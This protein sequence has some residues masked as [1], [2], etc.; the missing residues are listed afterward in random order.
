M[1]ARLLYGGAGEI[2][3]VAAGNY[4]AGE[5][6]SPTITGAGVAGVVSGSAPVKTGDRFTVLTRGVFELASASATTISKGAVAHW[7][8]TSNLAVASGGDFRVGPAL[9]A[10]TSGQLKVLVN[11][12]EFG[13]QP[14]T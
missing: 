9:V 2:H 13:D 4:S 14:D 7:N 5:I 1:Q 11:L 12:N 10:K 6:L 3:L 8:D